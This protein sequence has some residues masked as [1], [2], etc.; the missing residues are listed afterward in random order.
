MFKLDGQGHFWILGKFPIIVF[1]NRF[2]GVVFI[3]GVIP[4]YDSKDTMQSYIG[5][6]HSTASL[7][8]AIKS[9]SNP[10][11][12][13]FVIEQGTNNLIAA[14]DGELYTDDMKRYTALESTHPLTKRVA[15]T[16]YAKYGEKLEKLET[17]GT[18]T[19]QFYDISVHS[20]IGVSVCRFS[21]RNGIDWIFVSAFIV[22]SYSNIMAAIISAITF[23]A[24]LGV[25]LLIGGI[26][27]VFLLTQS[28]KKNIE[29][30]QKIENMDLDFTFG[31][32]SIFTELR[33]VQKTTKMAR[34]KL[35]EYRSFLPRHIL[36][37]TEPPPIEKKISSKASN[38]LKKY[39]TTSFQSASSG[40][41]K[42]NLGLNGI[43]ATIMK[44]SIDTELFD[45]DEDLFIERFSEILDEVS[46][47][48]N[49]SGGIVTS[50]DYNS[51]LCSWNTTR[52]SV[53]HAKRACTCALTIKRGM[54]RLKKK[55]DQKS[56]PPINTFIC[57]ASGYLKAG[58]I[59]CKSLKQYTFL[60]ELK[61]LVEMMPNI[62]IQY[63]VSILISGETKSSVESY[64]LTRLVVNVKYPK[65]GNVISLYQL[66]EQ[67]EN[68]SDEWMYELEQK[69]KMGVWD[70][71]N[72]ACKHLLNNNFTGAELLFLEFQKNNK[73]D[74]VVKKMIEYCMKKKVDPNVEHIFENK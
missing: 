62:N 20:Y 12:T 28:L 44:V 73:G 57:I 25:T 16:L 67:I 40:T 74:K 41:A 15:E 30:L 18:I 56:Y 69:Q 63:D 61:E 38:F 6:D 4:F 7:N 39:S 60:G 52:P 34:D 49:S 43:V 19:F 13:H 17:K 29:Y 2:P 9:V 11:S 36:D 42:F 3:S 14:S 5:L 33:K 10:K 27:G 46:K 68:T 8:E 53:N 70:Q 71:Y 1:N 35:L 50:F 65:I 26:T 58:N 64:F 66:G 54:V 23:S 48:V 51:I 59:G 55:W 47:A 45:D 31:K 32:P 37:C 22:N 21:I 72:E 24:F